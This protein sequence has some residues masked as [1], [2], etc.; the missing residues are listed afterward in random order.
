MNYYG[1]QPPLEGG[2]G[3]ENRGSDANEGGNYNLNPY[4]S[5]RS[6]QPQDYTDY[7]GT[8]AGAAGTSINIYHGF[9]GQDIMMRYH[10]T[11]QTQYPSSD[12]RPTLEDAEGLLHLAAQVTA[13]RPHP[14]PDRNHNSSLESACMSREAR[15][16]THA[17]PMKKRA[18]DPSLFNLD[19]DGRCDETRPAVDEDLTQTKEYGLLSLLAEKALEES[20][21]MAAAAAAREQLHDEQKQRGMN[22]SMADAEEDRPAPR[23]ADVGVTKDTK[24]SVVA[25]ETKETKASR[26]SSKARSPTNEED[27]EFKIRALVHGE[28][29]TKPID[30]ICGDGGKYEGQEEA[31][32]APDSTTDAAVDASSE[33]RNTDTADSSESVPLEPTIEGKN[34]TDAKM[35]DEDEPSKGKPV[36]GVPETIEEMAAGVVVVDERQSD[37]ATPVAAPANTS[38]VVPEMLALQAGNSRAPTPTPD[39]SDHIAAASAPIGLTMRT[40]DII[41]DAGP[42]TLDGALSAEATT[43]LVAFEEDESM[44][45][46]AIDEASAVRVDREGCPSDATEDKHPEARAMV[47]EV[48][49]E[50]SLASDEKGPCAPPSEAATDSEIL[51]APGDLDGDEI[52]RA[53][54]PADVASSAE[55]TTELATAHV[56]DSM[57]IEAIDEA[58]AALVDREDGPSEATKDKHPEARA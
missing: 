44:M 1:Q 4:T 11:Q 45:A 5:S 7:A 55:A 52:S 17:P 20:N 36:E 54:P 10:G 37:A 27:I 34:P 9:H 29:G 15:Y 30:S 12:S 26:G 58:S 35:E 49:K 33:V 42:G 6:Q 38:L 51:A 28:Y 43:E 32:S 25:K 22:E 3:G 56:E 31:K 40:S 50:Q 48:A 21:A 39:V 57:V 8:S 19:G 24:R 53:A 23:P 13:L 18:I 46:K 41:S 47:M 14:V 16:A 2:G